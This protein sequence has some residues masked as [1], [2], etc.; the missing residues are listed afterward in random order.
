VSATASTSGDG[1][2][3]GRKNNQN[4]NNR[5]ATFNSSATESG[6]HGS[7]RFDE[8]GSDAPLV[9]P[10]GSDGQWPDPDRLS[11]PTSPGCWR[12]GFAGQGV[13]ARAT[14]FF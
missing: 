14:D 7:S 9:D 5:A 10:A 2:S 4:S 1:R 12:G 6:R 11:E 3:S 13:C 8:E